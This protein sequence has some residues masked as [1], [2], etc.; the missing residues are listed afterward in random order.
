MEENWLS[1]KKNLNFDPRELVHHNNN[2]II[3]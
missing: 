1:K 2:K 3:G